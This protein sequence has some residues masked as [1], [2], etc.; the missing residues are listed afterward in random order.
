MYAYANAP[1]DE[2]TIS[3]TCFSSEDKTLYAF[4]RG[5][6]GLKGLPNFFTTQMYSLFKKTP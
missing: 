1:L 4:I 2:K 6:Y 5:L 3:L